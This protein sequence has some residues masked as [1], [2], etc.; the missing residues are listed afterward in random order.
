M[1]SDTAEHIDFRAISVSVASA[2][3]KFPQVLALLDTLDARFHNALDDG[4]PEHLMVLGE[5]GT[6]KT[7]TLRHFCQKHPP[8]ERP[9]VTEVPVVYA[10]IPS[11]TTIKGLAG[12]LLQAMGSPY[13]N[14]G[15]QIQRTHQLVTLLRACRTRVVILD[16]ANHLVDRGGVRTH[17][18]IGDWIKQL[19]R[20]GGP[21]LV[22][23]GTP[24]AELLLATNT[25]LRG[26]FGECFSINPLSANGEDLGL[27]AKIL[28]SFEAQLK[29]IECV[30][31]GDPVIARQFAFATAGRLRAICK[32]LRGAIDIAAKQRHPR[33]DMKVLEQAFEKVLLKSAPPER[34]PFS[35]KFNGVPLTKAGEPFAPEFSRG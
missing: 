30:K 35:G 3:G 22:L 20:P 8:I 27:F 24:R 2:F 29:P 1:T 23:A 34:N 28:R 25:Q 32:L 11:K 4:E 6:G 21:A 31:F 17:Y 7:T 14:K 33:I 26:R 18:H 10:E 16:E 9:E 15:D 13:W 5:S 19:S 12:T